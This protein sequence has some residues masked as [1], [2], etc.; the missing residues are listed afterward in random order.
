MF[1]FSTTDIHKKMAINFKILNTYVYNLLVK[2]PYRVSN[3]FIGV[4]NQNL[5]LRSL[6]T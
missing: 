2:V 6:P 1:P 4:W 5:K 3:L